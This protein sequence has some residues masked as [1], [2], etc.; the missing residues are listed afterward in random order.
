MSARFGSCSGRWEWVSRVHRRAVGT[1]IAP[2]VAVGRRVAAARPTT[3]GTRT[4]VGARSQLVTAVSANDRVRAST[5]LVRR[6]TVTGAAAETIG[7]SSVVA[8]AMTGTVRGR[9]QNVVRVVGSHRATREMAAGVVGATIVAAIGIREAAGKV[10][11]VG[12]PAENRGVTATP[13]ALGSA[14]V[15]IAQTLA[16]WGWSGSSG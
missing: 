16:D 5:A 2:R 6:V 14:R 12:H 15:A 13:T 11:A 1:M 4:T 3:V 8:A 9:V 10:S 7:P